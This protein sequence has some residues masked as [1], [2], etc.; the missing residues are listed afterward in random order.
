[1]R[2]SQNDIRLSEGNNQV[3][4]QMVP[5]VVV[6][7]GGFT[8]YATNFHPEAIGW[9]ARYYYEGWHHTFIWK[10]LNE[11]FSMS[12]ID[13]N[14]VVIL[15]GERRDGLIRDV[16]YG[17]YTGLEDGGIYTIDLETGKLR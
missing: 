2:Q 12:P 1:M 7:E 5:I 9:R 8:L 15:V 16:Q 4:V 14:N 10:G 6:Q 17:P 11:S 3:N 13:L